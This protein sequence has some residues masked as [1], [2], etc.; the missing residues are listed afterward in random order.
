[1]DLR[2]KICELCSILSLFLVSCDLKNS[3]IY[4]VEADVQ[5]D[6]QKTFTTKSGIK[7][8]I[9]EKHP[10]GMSLSNVVIQSKGLEHELNDTL[11]DVDPIAEVF[12]TDLDHNG[13]DEI[14]IIT[15]SVGSGSYA[16]VISYASNK[17][18]SM[19]PVFMRE[20]EKPDENYSGHDRFY[21]EEGLLVRE[22]ET[23]DSTLE[24]NR[25]SIK[26]ELVP[27]EASW[28]LE[29]TRD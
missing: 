20:A 4:E 5:D 29:R 2:F 26:Y 11:R 7:I 19:T 24:K 12:I 22:F 15:Q 9:D 6:V 25:I 23:V 18:K 21:L 28:Q 1:M 27:G 16:K 14:Y 10:V 17:D 13:F 3:P 8:F